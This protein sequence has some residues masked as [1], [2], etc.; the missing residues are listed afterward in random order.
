M[1]YSQSLIVTRREAP[2]DAE[3]VSHQ[4]MVRAS[5]IQ[6]VAS[7][8][9][10]YLPL[11]WRILRKIENIIREEMLKAGAEELLLPIVMPASL[12]KET[13]R[14]DFYGKELLRI[15]DRKENDF[16]FGP[17][18]EEAI[19]DLVRQT[20]KSY[21][22]LP[23]NLFQIQTKF[24]DEI[25]PR[26]GLMRGREFIM[27]DGYSFDVDETAAQKTYQ[28]MYDAY[29]NIFKRC[30]LDFRPVEAM[31]GA[32]GGSLS[33]E[34]QV[35]AKSGEDTILA[36]STTDYAASADKAPLGPLV[37]LDKIKKK[38]GALEKVATPNLTTVEEVATF[39]DTA[40]EN[41]A[42]ILLFE[43]EGEPIAALVRGD[44][45]LVEDKL[46]V[47]AG[48]DH[49][50]KA[51]A[52]TIQETLTSAVGFTGPVGL[53]I[54]IYADYAVAAMQDFVTGANEMDAHFK[55]VN[56]GDFEVKGF[57]DLR[58]AVAG[59]LCPKGGAYEEHR[60]IE[61][62]QV[63]YL[64]DKY[65]KSMK[66]VFLDDQGKEQTMVMGCYGIG[67][68]RT[69]AAAIEQ[70]HDDDGI[71]WPRAIAPYECVLLSLQMKDEEVARISEQLYRQL[72]KKGVDLIWDDRY[73]SPGVKFKDADLIGYPYQ[74]I[75]GPKGLKSDQ[76]EF[77][78]R[79]SGKKEAIPVSEVEAF[80][81]KE[82]RPCVVKD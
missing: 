2:A 4:L 78:D 42:K 64:G 25:R 73:E 77:K 31:T 74:L 56:L 6:K 48:V 45:E 54:P 36:S 38:S 55:K 15:K 50:E 18:H 71:I 29:M 69:A 20:V 7:G 26:F 76:V 34:F 63:F 67:V 33:H 66:A 47:V 43:T 3:T 35:L 41:L 51:T 13:G 70:H 81:L 12:W 65:S 27:K 37:A 23:L 21:R 75:V 22:Q 5:M 49:L 1:R 53:K 52:A 79:R 10:S 61:V 30:G 19:T 11:G 59:D 72:T 14:W 9:Y 68:G 44:H 24:R 16:C 60:G 46:K 82:M 40:T 28:K 32:I 17:T 8:I 62:G 57:Y 80:L 58:R 39:L